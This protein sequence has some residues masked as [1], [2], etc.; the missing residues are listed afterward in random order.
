[1]TEAE[2]GTE[3]EADLFRA[4]VSALKRILTISSSPP[5]LPPASREKTRSVKKTYVMTSFSSTTSR[6]RLPANSSNPSI[7]SKISLV[8]GA[9]SRTVERD[10]RICFFNSEI[11]EIVV[12]SGRRSFDSLNGANSWSRTRIMR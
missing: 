6:T 4:E 10:C 12:E 3:A 11:V 7:S 2:A 9:V 1:M 5:V 8:D